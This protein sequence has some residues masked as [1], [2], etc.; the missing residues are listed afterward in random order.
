[1]PRVAFKSLLPAVSLLMAENLHMYLKRRKVKKCLTW[2]LFRESTFAACRC[3]VPHMTFIKTQDSTINLVL[4]SSNAIR[5]LSN[6]E[7]VDLKV[8]LKA[9]DNSGQLGGENLCQMEE[10]SQLHMKPLDLRHRRK[11][12]ECCN[13]DVQLAHMEISPTMSRKASKMSIWHLFVC[14]HPA[15]LAR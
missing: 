7:D 9:M 12:R 4:G 14:L 1:M 2:L 3:G 5:A 6:Q 8:K 11:E 13:L 10:A 15:V